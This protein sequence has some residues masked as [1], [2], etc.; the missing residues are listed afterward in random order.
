M[1][2]EVGALLYGKS[3]QDLIYSFCWRILMKKTTGRLWAIPFFA[4]L[5]TGCASMK[6][7]DDFAPYLPIGIISIVSNNDIYW[8]G[9]GSQSKKASDNPEK[10]KISKADQLINDADEILWDLFLKTFITTY[11]GK[12]Q[13]VNSEAYQNAEIN[14]RLDNNRHVIASGYRY[15][16]YRDKQFAANLAQERGIKGGVYIT[17]DFSKKMASG[18]GKH[19]TFR[20]L[21]EM[22]VIIINEEGNVIFRKTWSKTS[23]EKIPISFGNYDHG[24]LMEVFKVVIEDLYLEYIAAFDTKNAYF[25]PPPE[26]II[27]EVPESSLF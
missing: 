26:G 2:L 17:F 1:F 6:A 7:P 24:E 27:P 22:Q 13:T 18:L 20:A 11:E 8:Y 12:A 15:I 9:E 23:D 10:T 14:R 21:A 4:V 5:A 16:N 25:G 3:E 19:G